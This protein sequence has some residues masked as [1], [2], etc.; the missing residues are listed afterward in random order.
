MSNHQAPATR[1]VLDNGLTLLI[2]ENHF[3]QTVAISG[4]VEGRQHV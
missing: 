3:N 1:H 4:T 2:Q